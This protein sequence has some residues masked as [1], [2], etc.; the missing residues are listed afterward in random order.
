MYIFLIYLL[1]V[2]NKSFIFFIIHFSSFLFPKHLYKIFFSLI[3][4]MTAYSYGSRPPLIMHGFL[5]SSL[6]EATQKSVFLVARL[7]K[8]EGGHYALSKNIF[9]PSGKSKTLKKWTEHILGCWVYK[10]YFWKP[11]LSKKFFQ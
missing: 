1:N 5:T 11:Y 3:F 4:A 7:L 6:R 2:D 10:N 9:F 8:R